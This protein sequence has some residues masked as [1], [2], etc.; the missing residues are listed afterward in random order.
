[1]E[2]KLD[3]GLFAMPGLLRLGRGGDKKL[4]LTVPKLCCRVSFETDAEFGDIDSRLAFRLIISLGT[5][6]IELALNSLEG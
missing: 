6:S 1:M 3:S 2:L 4:L 5:G